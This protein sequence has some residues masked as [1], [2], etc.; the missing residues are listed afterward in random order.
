MKTKIIN[1]PDLLKAASRKKGET[2]FKHASL[3]NKGELQGI[4]NGKSYYIKTYGCQANVRDEETMRGLFEDIGMVSTDK[5]ELASV[6]II[7]T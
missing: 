6:I 1:T 4:L 5:P 2:V 7:N 3:L